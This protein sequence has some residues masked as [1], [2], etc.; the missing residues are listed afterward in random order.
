MLHRSVKRS[1]LLVS[2]ITFAGCSDLLAPEPESSDNIADFE[3][4]WRTVHDVYP[5]LQFKRINWDSIHVVYRPRAEAA[6]GD[7]IDGVLLS[8]L[9][10]LRDAHVRLMSA[11]GASVATYVPP[12]S[13][14]DR[15]AYSPLVV[16][17]YFS[18]EL[19]LAG[20]DRIEY[21][22]V[23]GNVG[24][25]YISTLRVE[26]PILNGFDE[27]LEYLRNTKGL[28]I[29][30]RH[31]EGGTDWNSM[32]IVGRLIAVPL[33]GLPYLAPDGTLRSG[34]TIP[35]RGPFQYTKPV[36][37]LI[38]GVCF[39]A[40]EDFAEMMKH[41]PTVTAVG[42]TTSGGSGAPQTFALP[43]GRKINLST[44]FIRRYDGQ[45]IEWNGVPPDVRVEQTQADIQAGRDRQLEYAI[46]YLR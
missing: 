36:V 29:D 22:V 7:E 6:K 35:R 4:A 37:M 33:D 41:V 12:R 34:G 1:L 38:N 14:R 30:V 26:E 24:Y 40:C 46:A 27:A 11:G 16:R 17:K 28:I 20:N 5:F 31:D 42:D 3:A 10:E 45:P 32:G 23:G 2:F 15:F 18:A 13:I 39:S 44:K 8:L 9:M 43:S 19:R 25:I 21:E